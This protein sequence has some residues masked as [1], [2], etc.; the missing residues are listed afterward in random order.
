[1]KYEYILRRSRRKSISIEVNKRLEIIVRAPRFVR[2]KD[3]DLFVL[4]KSD[5]IDEALKKVQAKVNANASIEH[6]TSEDVQNLSK[7]AKQVIPLR[8]AYFADILGVN[9]GRISIRSQHTRWGSCSAK[10]NLNFNCL[11][12]LVPEEILDYVIVHE[13]CHLIELNH[14]PAFW[15]E[16][17]RVL[18]DY[19]ARRKWLKDNGSRLIESLPG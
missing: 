18:P 13:L 3:I 14:S 6:L 10:G 8:V 11:L 15:A 5:W 12:M 16:V 17:E 9:Y 19:K 1:M 7:Q 4:E 2:K